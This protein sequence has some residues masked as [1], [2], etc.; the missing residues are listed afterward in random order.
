MTEHLRPGDVLLYKSTGL[1]SWLIR[2]KTWH[3]VSHVEVYIGAGQ[4]A[5]SRDG[6]GTGL[7]PLREDGLVSVLRPVVPFQRAAALDWYHREAKGLPYGWADLLQFTGLN[8]DR[9]GI[10]C[11]PFATL[12]LRAGG[13]PVF[14][15]EPANKIAPFQFATS[16][17]LREVS[18]A[19]REPTA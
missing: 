2:V 4:S 8:V 7:Y 9:R 17:L 18:V 1:F 19:N 10:V 13:V 16:E 11:S 5:A 6:K 12:F 15:A 3:A 14:N